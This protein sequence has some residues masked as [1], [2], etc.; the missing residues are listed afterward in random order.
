MQKLHLADPGYM[1]PYEFDEGTPIT[2]R[3]ALSIY[4]GTLNNP[5]LEQSF[6]SSVRSDQLSLSLI[7][8][9]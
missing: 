4:L 6:C 3:G 8:R 9:S 7:A 1:L 5:V 2:S